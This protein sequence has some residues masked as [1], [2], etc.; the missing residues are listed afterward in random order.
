[1]TTYIANEL[2]LE[3]V[4]GDDYK[5]VDNRAISIAGRGV[6]WPGAVVSV[7]LIMYEAQAACPAGL[8]AQLPSTVVDVSGTF[9][10]GT[11]NTLPHC[12]FDLPRSNTLQLVVGVR[13][14]LCEVRGLLE[15]GSVVTLARGLVS[16]LPSGY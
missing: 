5:A 1:M 4:Q 13:R 6:V 10:A 11:A 15:S 3:L 16:V 7:K 2:L 14:Y 8:A 12:D 9:I